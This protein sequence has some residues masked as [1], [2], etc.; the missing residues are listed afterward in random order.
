LTYPAS[1]GR[2]FDEILRVIDSLQTTDKNKVRISSSED[3]NRQN[4]EKQTEEKTQ[5]SAV[6]EFLM[7]LFI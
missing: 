4:C 2:N 1:C 5:C 3:W 6:Q 7:D